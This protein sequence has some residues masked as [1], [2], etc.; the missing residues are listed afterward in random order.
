MYLPHEDTCKDQKEEK[1]ERLANAN[2]NK[3]L[4]YTN[5]SVFI[6]SLEV[7]SKQ[8]LSV[9]G[10]VS[11]AER[12]THCTF[13]MKKPAKI[14]H[15]NEESIN[16]PKIDNKYYFFKCLYILT[17][18]ESCQQTAIV[19]WGVSLSVRLSPLSSESVTRCTCSTNITT[20]IKYNNKESS[21]FTNMKCD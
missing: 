1:T 12:V 9:W 7:A 11:F 18:I 16:F 10:D 8:P 21:T 6:P 13:S 5:V 20:R 3:K 15:N 17:F 2:A 14:K 4:K 19:L